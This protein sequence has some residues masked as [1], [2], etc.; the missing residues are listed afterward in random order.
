MSFRLRVEAVKP[1]PSETLPRL[2][3]SE[4]MRGFDRAMNDAGASFATFHPPSSWLSQA[5]R[6]AECVNASPPAISC[7]ARTKTSLLA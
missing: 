7:P 4:Y 5:R 3:A 1:R 6:R 2:N